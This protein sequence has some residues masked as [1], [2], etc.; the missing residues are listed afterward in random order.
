[1]RP[2]RRRIKVE[3]RRPILLQAR[4]DLNLV[5]DIVRSNGQEE[6]EVA[7]IFVLAH[8]KPRKPTRRPARSRTPRSR[9][10]SDVTKITQAQ[11]GWMLIPSLL[12]FRPPPTP[13]ADAQHRAR[14]PQE[15]ATTRWKDV[16]RYGRRMREFWLRKQTPKRKPV[17][18]PLGPGIRDKGITPSGE[19]ETKMFSTFN[20]TILKGRKAA[21]TA[22]T[23]TPLSPRTFD[24]HSG[25]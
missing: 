22:S 1:M 13:N 18:K 24:M 7:R 5:D 17:E 14:E 16:G 21:P 6:I 11:S 20:F 8:L 4:H 2:H 3:P 9:T 23:L 19:Q 15:L 12:C 25:M 10:G